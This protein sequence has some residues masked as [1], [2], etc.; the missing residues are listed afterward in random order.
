MS[1]VWLVLCLGN[2][3]TPGGAGVPPQSAQLAEDSCGPVSLY[4]FLRLNGLKVSYDDVVAGF[5]S[6]HKI[7]ATLADMKQ[8]AGNCGLAVECV[9]VRAL[10]DV[11]R[12]IIAYLN[13]GDRTNA[14]HYIVVRPIGET[15][16]MVQVIS[17]PSMPRAR[18][19][20]DLCADPA[21]TGIV[22]VPANRTSRVP[23]VLVGV[24]AV[25]GVLGV[26]ATVRS[27]A[28]RRLA[29]GLLSKSRIA[30]LISRDHPSRRSGLGMSPV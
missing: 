25:G 3:S 1:V 17:P 9:R 20:S 28:F 6:H 10:P 16:T 26:M 8:A 14:G 4:L 30:T 11:R 15:G 18:D 23:S 5:G 21:W 13:P 7:G 24:I 19:R 12:S 27:S 2:V 22:I 29:L